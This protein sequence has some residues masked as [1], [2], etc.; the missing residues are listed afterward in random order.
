MQQ[1]TKNKSGFEPLA[2]KPKDKASAIFM[3]LLHKNK[4]LK[5]WDSIKGDTYPN[6]E[7]KPG[8]DLNDPV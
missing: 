3:K 5:S 8:V 7:I 4:N 1:I 2:H 6:P